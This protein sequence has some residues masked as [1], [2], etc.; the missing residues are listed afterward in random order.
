M[1]P[2]RKD[3][4]IMDRHD[5]IIGA[6]VAFILTG[7][8]AVFIGG[9]APVVLPPSQHAPIAADQ[10]NLYQK[11]PAKYEALGTITLPVTPEMKWDERGES[12]PGF[13]ALKA[14][15]AAMGANG[16][17]LIAQPGTFDL[18]ATAGY[19]GAWYQVPMKSQPKAAVVQA[20][21][22]VTQ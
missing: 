2:G 14:K 3:E 19:R 6:V 16:V 12:T 22:V 1:S 11:Q 21:F 5:Q 7:V 17:L 18:L 4:Q 15:A 10:V 8:L 20:I 13:D 9:C